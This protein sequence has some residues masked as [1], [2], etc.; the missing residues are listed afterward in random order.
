M[1]ELNFVRQCASGDKQSW[2][3]FVERYS[4][5]I[6]SYI[7]SVFQIKGSFATEDI[8][9]ELFHEIFLLLARDNFKKL[10]SFKAK[11]RCSLASWLRQVTV[12]FT[13]DY[14][15]KLRPTVSIDEEDAQD[16]SLKDI[17]VDE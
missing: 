6:Y 4:R 11:N 16:L 15:R 3:R 9:N 5:L 14:I 13:I 10:K 12:N 7:Y 2:E 8:R 1:D 17:L